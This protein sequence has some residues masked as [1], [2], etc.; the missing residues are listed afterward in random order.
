LC[1]SLLKRSRNERERS[2]EIQMS[3]SI[4]STHDETRGMIKGGK[5][6]QNLTSII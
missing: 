1:K 6:P 2:I 3:R 5:E 4:F